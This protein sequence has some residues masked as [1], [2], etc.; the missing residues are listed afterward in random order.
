[1]VVLL[2]TLR[3]AESGDWLNI[4][5][6]LVAPFH[7]FCY[8]TPEYSENVSNCNARRDKLPRV[9]AKYLITN[10][11]NIYIYKQNMLIYIHIF[12]NPINSTLFCRD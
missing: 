5:G 8:I 7:I 10:R 6:R 11:R 2:I 9:P 3:L 4:I 12:L 1:M